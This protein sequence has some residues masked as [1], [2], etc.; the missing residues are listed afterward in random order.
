MPG[1]VVEW[2]LIVLFTACGISNTG[3]KCFEFKNGTLVKHGEGKV[4]DHKTQI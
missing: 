4:N 2:Y 3:Q 1:S